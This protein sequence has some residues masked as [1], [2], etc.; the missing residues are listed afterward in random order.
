MNFYQKIILAITLA[1]IA[2]TLSIVLVCF[3]APFTDI[4]ITECFAIV[5]SEL[6]FGLTLISSL[7]K[8][9]HIFPYSI[10][11]GYIGL[12][13]FLFTVIMTYIACQDIQLKY[14][15]LIHITGFVI[16]LIAYGLFS[17][18]EHNITEQSVEDKKGLLGKKEFYR[19]MYHIFEAWKQVFRED[20]VLM[21]ESE[22]MVENF[23]YAADSRS[24]MEDVD[25]KINC[26]LQNMHTAVSSADIEEYR[27]NFELL[28]NL[29]SDREE[30]A[31]LH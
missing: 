14:F 4:F 7:K 6:L 10:Y 26:I 25:Q 19:Q 8:S 11:S 31:K 18:G 15:I 27:K 17:L 5:W 3:K 24:G 1:V 22:T 16:I 20:I 9:D 23:R 13:Y 21:K 12:T 30:M 28:K 2:I 29:Y